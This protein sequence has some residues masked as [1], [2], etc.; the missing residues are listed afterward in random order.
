MSFNKIKA[1]ATLSGI[2][3]AII[4]SSTATA[5]PEGGGKG[6]H[7]GPPP[8]AIE[9]CSGQAENDSCSFTSPRGDEI[10]GSCII[11]PH[12]EAEL[13]CAPEGGPPPHGGGQRPEKP[14]E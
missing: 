8:E 13:I 4:L 6:G 14:E 11:P 1:I 12:N 7:R 5:M 2:S 9:A 10:T 3:L